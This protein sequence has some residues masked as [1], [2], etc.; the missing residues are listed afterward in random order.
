MDVSAYPPEL[1]RGWKTEAYQRTGKLL[2]VPFAEETTPRSWTVIRDLVR[3][4]LCEYQT[5]GKVSEDA[6]YRS[7]AGALYKLFF[8]DLP[9][10]NTYSRQTE[11]W[12]KTVQDISDDALESTN[13]RAA[14]YSQKFPRKYRVMMEE[15]HT[16]SLNVCAQKKTVLNVIEN[17]VRDLFQTGEVFG[18]K[19]NNLR[20]V[21]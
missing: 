5:H 12:L 4:C 6:R 13:C 2:S 16:Y 7:Y 18:L 15:L 10:Q 11:L 3:V 14:R 1:L 9:G 19:D 20:P 21:F 8:E 17:T